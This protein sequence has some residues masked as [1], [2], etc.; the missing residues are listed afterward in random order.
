MLWSLFALLT[1]GAVFAIL[2]PLARPARRDSTAPDVAFYEAKLEEIARDEARANI[3]PEEAAAAKT[4]AARQLLA[5]SGK[6]PLSTGEPAPSPRW[7]LRLAAVAALI[8]I[9]AI[10]IGFYAMLGHPSWPDDPLQAR[11]NAP[12]GHM[13]VNAAIAK[14]E[15]HLR[16]DPQDGLGYQVLAQAYLLVG[17]PRD[18][19][20]AAQMAARL[21]GNDANT[22]TVYGETLVVASNGIVTEDAR[23][24][25]EKALKADP[26]QTKALFFL[27]L[28][29]SQE[30]DRKTARSYWQKLLAEAPADAPWRADLI[31]RLAQLD[32]GAPPAG[33]AAQI[34][35][36][37]PAAQQAAI[38]SMVDGLATRL[39]QHG[40]DIEGWVRLV[41]A[42]K[43][44]NEIDKARAA[45][46]TARRDFNG[47]A[48][49]TARIDALAHELGLDS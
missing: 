27:G 11:L 7:H 17:R 43:V 28:A 4:E 9:P 30:N 44:L 39:S 25:F 32:S 33:K 15:A 48:A 5:V 18:A 47:D 38:Q 46:K 16:Q 6:D 49:A 1:G 22:L 19:V 12:I 41:R 26:R 8:F 13:D 10:A 24:Q 14:V 40:N 42:Y 20:D 31:A 2:W 36:M 29:A 37:A 35:A 21:R 34:A 23:H 45:L 3:S